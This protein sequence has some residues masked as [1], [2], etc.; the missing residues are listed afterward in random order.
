MISCQETY[1]TVIYNH[2]GELSCDVCDPPK[3]TLTLEDGLFSS[4]TYL[5]KK[6][7]SSSQT[8]HPICRL[9]PVEPNPKNPDIQ[10]PPRGMHKLSRHA[11]PFPGEAMAVTTML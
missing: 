3:K 6:C 9:D 10:V 8:V 1:T 11:G 5:I 7:F 4:M 2:L